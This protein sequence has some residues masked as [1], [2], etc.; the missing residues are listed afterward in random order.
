[1]KD[2]G[3]CRLGKKGLKNYV[4]VF[5]VHKRLLQRRKGISRLF[6]CFILGK[7]NSNG[8]NLQQGTIRLTQGTVCNTE[9]D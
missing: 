9:D 4:T 3:L 6:M 7:S 1:M 2:L 8:L 5:K